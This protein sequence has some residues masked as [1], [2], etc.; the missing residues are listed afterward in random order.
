MACAAPDANDRICKINNSQRTKMTNS[1]YAPPSSESKDAPQEAGSPV[2]A[3]VL[4][5]L[6]D[7]G[8]TMATSFLLSIVFAVVWANQ[9][10][11]NE[12][13]VALMSDRALSNPF[14]LT[15]TIFGTVCS[16]LGGFIC[17][18]IVRRS[19]IRYGA[20]LAAISV[21]VGFAFSI[22]DSSPVRITGLAILSVV[23]VMLGTAHGRA[24]NRG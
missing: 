14:T 12:Q 15:A 21:L 18:R 7:I 10:M 5:L 17:A 23:V 13:V 22:G 8:G 20:V 19:E 11:S 9:G 24:I 2:K 3:I 4:G 16:Y 6:T 1:P